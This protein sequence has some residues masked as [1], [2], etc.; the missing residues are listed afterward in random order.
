LSLLRSVDGEGDGYV[1]RGEARGRSMEH[2]MEG[3]TLGEVTSA[4][5]TAVAEI[6]RP[7]AT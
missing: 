7:A 2:L 5:C 1:V 4:A 6:S 3:T